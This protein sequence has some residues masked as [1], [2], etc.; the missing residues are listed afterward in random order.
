LVEKSAA[1]AAFQASCAD[2]RQYVL[3]AVKSS[4]F[5]WLYNSKFFRDARSIMRIE[6]AKARASRSHFDSSVTNFNRAGVALR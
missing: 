4:R 5:R 1:Q 6:A 3:H 2:Y